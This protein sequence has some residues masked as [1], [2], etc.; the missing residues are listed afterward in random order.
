[1]VHANPNP[2][3]IHLR[4]LSGNQLELPRY[5]RS[6]RILLRD[7]NQFHLSVSPTVKNEKFAYHISK[8]E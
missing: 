6:A 7:F 2:P 5:S 4:F 8:N 1:M 3:P